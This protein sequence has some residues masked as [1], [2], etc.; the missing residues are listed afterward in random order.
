MKVVAVFQ[1]YLPY[2][3]PRTSAWSEAPYLQDHFE[4]EGHLVNVHPRKA[5]ESLFPGVVDQ[6]LRDLKINVDWDFEA[7]IDAPSQISVRDRC[8]DRLEAQVFGEVPSYQDCLKS[9]VT[10]EYRRLALGGCN[11]FLYHCR[12]AGRDPEIEGLDWHY[13]FDHARCYFAFPH[14]LTWFDAETKQLLHNDKGDPLWAAHPGAIRTPVRLPVELEAIQQS[15]LM[16]REP[17]L[18]IAFLVSAKKHIQADQLREGIINL[19]TASEIASNRY[20]EGSGLRRSAKVRAILNMKGL[21][22]AQKHYHRLPLELSNR[23]LLS[24]DPNAF[25]ELENTYKTRNSVVHT[26]ELVYN[27]SSGTRI[28]VIRSTAVE[29]LESCE[30][31]IDWIETL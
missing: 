14:S 12:L 20:V 24:D 10:F 21:T 22:F 6:N 3:L 23:S 18:P 29:F 7:P 26:G 1:M 9:E 27:D 11:S 13:S 2:F 28:S 8:F 5:G 17:T 4:V 31:A 25:E 19:A 30:A 16:N 15:F